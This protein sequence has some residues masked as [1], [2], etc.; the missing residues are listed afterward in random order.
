ME[1]T[2]GIHEK[3]SDVHVENHPS[4]E[5]VDV[6]DTLV[7]VEG[8]IWDGINRKTVLAFLVC[9]DSS[10]A[11]LPLTTPLGGRPSVVN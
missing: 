7:H 1:T 3:E 10:T 2:Q 6:V 9:K 11:H 8:E 4:S 5:N